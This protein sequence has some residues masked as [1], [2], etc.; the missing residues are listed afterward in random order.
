MQEVDESGCV[1]RTGHV[2]SVCT[3]LLRNGGV[4]HNNARNRGSVIR[5][6]EDGRRASGNSTIGN[7]D[8]EEANTDR[9]VGVLASVEET[10]SG[11]SQRAVRKQEGRVVRCA[12]H[13]PIVSV[14][15][16]AGRGVVI[17]RRE[18]TKEE[19]VRRGWQMRKRLAEGGG[20]PETGGEVT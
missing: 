12:G 9:H 19:G 11:A 4:G 15:E 8:A 18:T 3:Q 6:H 20:Q 5:P 2:V 7:R 1:D 14:C 13:G 16:G 10:N 17:S